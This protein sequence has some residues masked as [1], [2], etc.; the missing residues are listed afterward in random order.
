[1]QCNER[2]V[3]V[4]ICIRANFLHLGG[5]GKEWGC[6]HKRQRKCFF[7]PFHA[8]T[9]IHIDHLVFNLSILTDWEKKGEKSWGLAKY[10]KLFLDSDVSF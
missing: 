1:M 10:K 2:G 4:Y 8:F 6:G 9:Y 3:Y 5:K 7:D